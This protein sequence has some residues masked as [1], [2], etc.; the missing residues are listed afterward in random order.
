M[1]NASPT[2]LSAVKAGETRLR[3]KGGAS[4]ESLYALIN[5]HVDASRAPTSRFGT[6]K[7]APINEA[8]ESNQ[9]TL[10]PGT[11]G[12]A[13]FLGKR[14]VFADEPVDLD[15]DG[16]YQLG[17]LRHPSDPAASLVRVSFAKPIMRA[18]YVVAVFDNGD[19]Y[20]YWLRSATTWE[21]NHIYRIG[22]IVQ[23]TDPNGFFYTAQRATEPAD[24]WAP[25]V[26]REVG[27]VVE[28]TVYNGYDYIVIET[29]GANPRSGA[30]EPNW[31]AQDTATIEENTDGGA[32]GTPT[33]PTPGGGGTTLPPDIDDRYNRDGRTNDERMIQ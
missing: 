17:I 2:A 10:P 7:R 32:P 26:A 28:P 16:N 1:P 15:V 21:A 14:W 12:L 8:A 5:G 29:Y 20:H 33:T 24:Q 25:N 3:Y 13:Y 27:D 6:R 9:T 4:P 19:C 22:E 23:P 18:L 11:I 30:V 31:P